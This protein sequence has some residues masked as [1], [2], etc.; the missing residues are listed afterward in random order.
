MPKFRQAMRHISLTTEGL[1]W[2]AF[3]PD[4]LAQ[5]NGTLG[6]QKKKKRFQITL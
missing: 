1:I 4:V 2:L 6:V 3:H 5:K